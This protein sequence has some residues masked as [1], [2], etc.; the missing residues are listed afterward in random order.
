MGKLSI[1]GHGPL[2]VGHYQKVSIWI[3]FFP[4][5]PSADLNGDEPRAPVTIEV[6]RI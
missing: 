2:F 5:D 3:R 6:T 1:N 4:P